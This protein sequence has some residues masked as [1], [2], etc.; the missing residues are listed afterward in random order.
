[1]KSADTSS[2]SEADAASVRRLVAEAADSLGGLVA[3]HIKLARV[4]LTADVRVYVGAA[5]GVVAAVLFMVMGYG[6]AS[7]AAALGLARRTGMPVAFALL[8]AL[9]LLV[10]GLCVRAAMGRV[11]RIRVLRETLVEARQS[12]RALAHRTQRLTS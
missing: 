11:R 3:D 10:G 9:Q 2:N 6:L 4:E 12:V 7:V 5:G 8:A 1:M